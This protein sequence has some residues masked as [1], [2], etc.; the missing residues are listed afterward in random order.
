MFF[1][2]A[3]G[4]FPLLYAMLTGRAAHEAVFVYSSFNAFHCYNIPHKSPKVKRQCGT[5]GTK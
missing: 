1:T 2:T 4:S 3:K 5:L